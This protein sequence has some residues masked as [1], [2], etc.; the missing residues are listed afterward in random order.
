MINAFLIAFA[1]TCGVVSAV[2]AFCLVYFAVSVTHKLMTKG[3]TV[4]L[5]EAQSA[6][7]AE[8]FNQKKD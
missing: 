4:T 7:M 6:M 3:V 5:T 1:A 2:M 8:M